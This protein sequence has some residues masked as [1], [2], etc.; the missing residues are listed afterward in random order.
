MN[1]NLSKEGCCCCCC[2]MF[3]FKVDSAGA[4]LVDLADDLLDL[5][6]GHVGIERLKD[7]LEIGSLDHAPVV[8]VEDAEGLAQLLLVLGLLGL[9]GHESEELVEVDAARAVAVHG[10]DALLELLGLQIVAQVLHDCAEHRRRY[11]A[12]ALFVVDV[13]RHTEVCICIRAPFITKNNHNHQQSSQRRR[14]QQQQH[15]PAICCSFKWY[16]S[17]TSSA[18]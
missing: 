4:V 11:L 16:S 18:F 3:T 12:L 14:Q 13:E 17:S 10:L 8:L 15:S 7:E 5:F 1:N 9:L 6:V 2:C